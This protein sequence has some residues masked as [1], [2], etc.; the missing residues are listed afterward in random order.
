VGQLDTA[1]GRTEKVEA[2]ARKTPVIKTKAEAV[3]PST[4]GAITT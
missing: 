4:Q 3:D 2:P 1:E